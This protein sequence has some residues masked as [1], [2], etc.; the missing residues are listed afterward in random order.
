ML[1][2]IS[3]LNFFYVKYFLWYVFHIETTNKSVCNRNLD[4]NLVCVKGLTG[5][6]TDRLRWFRADSPPHLI[7]ASVGCQGVW[8]WFLFLKNKITILKYGHRGKKK[9][10]EKI[11]SCVYRLR[12]IYWICLSKNIVENDNTGWK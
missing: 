5:S 6:F 4:I 3:K 2:L 8:F 11:K 7:S 12:I 10:K 1:C 9:A